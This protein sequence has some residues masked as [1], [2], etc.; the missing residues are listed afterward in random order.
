MNEVVEQL[1]VLVFDKQP[2]VML[3]PA[4]VSFLLA[5]V[6][7]VKLKPALGDEGHQRGA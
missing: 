5:I 3:I 6:L 4:M 7:K 1:G 2:T